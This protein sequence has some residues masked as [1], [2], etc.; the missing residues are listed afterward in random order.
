[1]RA[2][3]PSVRGDPCWA[4]SRD[5]I[6]LP[7]SPQGCTHGTVLC[8]AASPIS[9]RQTSLQVSHFLGTYSKL[10]DIAHIFSQLHVTVHLERS[11]GIWLC[12]AQGL[13]E[14]CFVCFFSCFQDGLREELVGKQLLEARCHRLPW[15]FVLWKV[16]VAQSAAG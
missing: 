6:R 2:H 16:K 10:W 12:R 13:Q 8:Q 7:S 1:M 9:C 14:G 15:K 5:G 4:Q 3:C 11:E